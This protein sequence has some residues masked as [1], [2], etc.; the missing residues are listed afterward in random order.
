MQLKEESA[1][2]TTAAPKI[3]IK[4]LLHCEIVT[5]LGASLCLKQARGKLCSMNKQLI[6]AMENK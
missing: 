3:R 2:S 1:N 6:I 4:A 5:L